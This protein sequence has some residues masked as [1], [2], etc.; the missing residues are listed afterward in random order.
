MSMLNLGQHL[1]KVKK[2]VDRCEYINSLS[3]TFSKDFGE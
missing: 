3:T 1:L 2:K